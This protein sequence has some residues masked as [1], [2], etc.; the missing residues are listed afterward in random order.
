MVHMM[1]PNII[2]TTGFA[3][4]QAAPHSYFYVIYIFVSQFNQLLGAAVGTGE[5]NR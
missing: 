5:E 3:L 2:K 1:A 4:F